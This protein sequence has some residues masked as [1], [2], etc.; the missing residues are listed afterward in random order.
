MSED[1][2]RFINVL[3]CTA[4]FGGLLWRLI[5]RFTVSFTMARIVVGLLAALELIVALGTARAAALGVPLNEAQ[6]AITV[7]ALIVLAV[8]AY[9]PRLLPPSWT[10]RK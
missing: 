8:V 5:G 1:V 3:L 9:W 10:P 7:H 2:I 4:A 6:Y